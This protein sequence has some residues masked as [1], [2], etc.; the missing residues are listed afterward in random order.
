MVLSIIIVNYNVK[1][2]LEQCLLSVR[3]ATSNFESEVLVIDNNST[4]GSRQYFAGKFDWVQFTWRGTNDG[5]AKACNEG[6]AKASGDYIL[7][8]NPDTLLSEDCLQKSLAFL[9]EKEN[10][11][12][13]GIQMIDGS[14]RFLK[15]SKR[16]FPSPITSIYKLSGLSSLFPTSP[17]FAKYHLGHLDKNATHEV[18]VLAGAFMMIPAEIIY[19]IGSFDERFFMYGEDIDLSYRIQQSGFSNYYFGES[20]IIHFKGESTRKDN[21][22]YVMLFYKAMS[23]FAKKHY[24]GVKAGAFNFLIQTGIFAT[25]IL[26][27]LKNIM[28]RLGMKIIDALVIFS[29]FWLAK[30]VWN[31]YIKIGTQ[32]S[33]KLLFIA[34]FLFTIMFWFTAYLSG[35]YDNGFKQSRLNKVTAI[36]LIILLAMYSLFPESIRFS[37][38]IIILGCLLAFSIMSVIRRWMLAW[39]ILTPAFDQHEAFET[40]VIGNELSLQT[41]RHFF[42]D[43]A[44]HKK[45]IG[46]IAVRDES[47]GSAI[48]KIDDFRT[49]IS[50]Y[51]IKELIFCIGDLP[52][53]KIIHSLSHL[54]ARMRVKFFNIDTHTIIQSEDSN[55]SGRIYFTGGEYVLALAMEQRK[56]RLADIFIATAFL[57]TFPVHLFIKKRPVKLFQNALRVLSGKLSFIGY[58]GNGEHLPKLSPGILTSTGLPA[59]LNNLPVADLLEFD[60]LYA[61]DYHYLKDL[62]SVWLNYPL[63]S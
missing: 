46:R 52:F 53:S 37:R 50:Q 18:D 19:K 43:Q 9:Q 13:L 35:L 31:T 27:G 26:A 11:C 28:K 48:G 44:V 15:E 49:T 25:G 29:S 23:K 10:K 51:S 7:F 16:S 14:G 59:R 24:A 1:F 8:L 17:I 33:G 2:F 20:S 56:K 63:L 55:A 42:D 4:D 62:Q 40:V 3:Q 32:Y 22:K 47:L 60:R 6:L 61:K 41:V 39:N 30:L 12:A 54:P 34:F 57:I 45:I 58:A 36:A 38:G 5:F 21:F